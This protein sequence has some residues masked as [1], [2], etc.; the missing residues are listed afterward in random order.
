MK[1]YTTLT[2]ANYK[3]NLVKTLFSHKKLKINHKKLEDTLKNIINN[4]ESS[5]NIKNIII[6]IAIQYMHGGPR[7]PSLMPRGIS[8]RGVVSLVVLSF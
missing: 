4:N 7:P 1:T 3:K 6:D 5:S 8:R 2:V